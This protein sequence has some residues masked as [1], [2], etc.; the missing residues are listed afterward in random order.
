MTDAEANQ[1]GQDS[2]ICLSTGI[3]RLL[4]PLIS[5]RRTQPDTYGDGYVETDGLSYANHI[6]C[7]P[8]ELESIFCGKCC[9]ESP[10]QNAKVVSKCKCASSQDADDFEMDDLIFQ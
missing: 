8:G 10:G 6:R 5:S 1:R 9:V 4:T 3:Q 2:L 7:I